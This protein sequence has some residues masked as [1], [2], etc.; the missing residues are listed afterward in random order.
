LQL[1]TGRGVVDGYLRE[2]GA[3][4][5]DT[6]ED[7]N[8]K[9]ALGFELVQGVIKLTQTAEKH[10]QGKDILSMLIDAVEH[11]GDMVEGKKVQST[12]MTIHPDH[13]A[14]HALTVAKIM[15]SV[16]DP[17]PTHAKKAAEAIGLG[18]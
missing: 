16:A 12:G 15:A 2:K 11:L 9:K 18:R 3:S 1:P 4:R 13:L 8:R 10:L 5:A 17:N 14:E 7:I 6:L